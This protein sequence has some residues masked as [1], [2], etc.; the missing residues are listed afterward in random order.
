MNIEKVKGHFTYQNSNIEREK[1]DLKHEKL[2]WILFWIL[3]RILL[4]N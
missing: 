2:I 1:K 3:F 4:L